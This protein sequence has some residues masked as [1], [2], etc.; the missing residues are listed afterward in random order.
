VLLYSGG[1]WDSAAYTIGYATCNTPLGPCTQA[2]T[3]RPLLASAGNQAGPG[4]ACVITGPDGDQWLAYHAW[5]AGAIGYINGG[6][7]SLRFT[8][9]TWESG[10]APTHRDTFEHVDR[11]GD[12]MNLLMLSQKVGCIPRLWHAVSSRCS[13]RRSG[14]GLLQGAVAE[15]HDAVDEPALVKELEIDACVGG[16]RRLAATDDY[17][18]AE[19]VALV[20]QPRLDS[21]R[22]EVRASHGEIAGRRHPHVVYRARV[23][24]AFEA[25]L[26]GRGGG[27][28]RV[29][30][31][32]LSVRPLMRVGPVS[33]TCSWSC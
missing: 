27:Q 4:G 28:G 18:P 7:R 21:L 24:V 20:N 19:Q 15:V 29:T 30:G 11:T 31:P 26:G 13:R 16:Q 6:P 5:S 2:T 25:G 1:W 3:D 8:S 14:R 17:G 22:G 32:R 9:L 10:E 23:E 33:P 12:V